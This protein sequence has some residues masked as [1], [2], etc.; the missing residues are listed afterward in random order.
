V[1]QADW[2]ERLTRVIA[3]EVRRHRVARKL[4]AQQLADR[5]EMLGFPVPRSVI[6]NLE[7]G[8]R[9]T[10][11]VAE[12]LVLA[13]ALDVAPVLLTVPLGYQPAAEI[14]P[15]RTLRAW[16]AVL[17][18]S[19]ETG[20]RDDPD[21]EETAWLDWQDERG[22]VPLYQRHDEA[23]DDL[24]H[25]DHE[26]VIIRAPDGEP[27]LAASAKLQREMRAGFETSL[28]EVRGRMRELG[29][30]PPDLPAELAHIDRKGRRRGSR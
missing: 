17:W 27:D 15:G 14:L 18:Q 11:S 2:Q 23:L 12:L 19:G 25:S 10:V 6:A 7:N 30:T 13:A 4:S 5:C 9:E 24:V 3:S 21:D 29:L 26:G 20:L 16:D 22:I 28:R 1:A 8:R